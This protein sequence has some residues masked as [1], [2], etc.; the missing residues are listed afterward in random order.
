MTVCPRRSVRW[1]NGE[2]RPCGLLLA[3]LLDRPQPVLGALDGVLLGLDLRLEIAAA[4]RH[5]GQLDGAVLRALQ[6]VLHRGNALLALRHLGAQHGLLVL[7]LRDARAK[8]RALCYIEEVR[9]ETD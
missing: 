7:E 1:R 2:A 9:G 8:D 6:G 4:P 3:L 5:V